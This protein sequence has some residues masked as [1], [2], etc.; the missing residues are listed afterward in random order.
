MRELAFTS[1]AV[2]VAALSTVTLDMVALAPPSISISFPVK[3]GGA[4]IVPPLNVSDPPCAK[5]AAPAGAELPLIVQPVAAT[6]PP[7]L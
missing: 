7:S 2:E 5:I 1:M 4:W 6:A 3:V